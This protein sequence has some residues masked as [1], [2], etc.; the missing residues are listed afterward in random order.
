MTI[1]LSAADRAAL[2]FFVPTALPAM[3]NN[4]RWARAIAAATIA[5]AGP[6]SALAPGEDGVIHTIAVSGISDVA[7]AVAIDPCLLYNLTLP[8]IRLV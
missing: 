4:S 3:R 2:R 8:T 5:L 6:V 1:L 7:H